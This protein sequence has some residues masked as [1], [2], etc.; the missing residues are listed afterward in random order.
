MSPGSPVGGAAV[1][2][3]L[4]GLIV[5]GSAVAGAASEVILFRMVQPPDASAA[6]L[7]GLW[8]ASPYLMAAGLALL[9]RRHGAALVTLLVALIVVG[10][11]GVSLLNASA[12]Q[13]EVAR[14]QAATAVLPGEDPSHGPG[15]MRKAG[16]DMGEFIGDAFS[17]LLVVVLVP[18]QLAVVGIPAA[19]AFGVSA[20]RRAAER[21]AALP[22]TDPRGRPE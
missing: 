6:A 11:V 8:I 21:E 1:R 18:V 19:V 13:Q 9:A 10:T 20:W 2:W 14:Q 22:V 17:I 5:M 4:V 7:A 16:A 12:T 3:G 15:G